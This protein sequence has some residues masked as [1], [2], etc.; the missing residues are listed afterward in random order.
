MI[1]LLVAVS[2]MVHP[3]LDKTQFSNI[4]FELGEFWVIAQQAPNMVLRPN[5][6]IIRAQARITI[7]PAATFS[8]TIEQGM[9][10]AWRAAL[11]GKRVAGEID[12]QE[13]REIQVGGKVLVQ[14]AQFSPQ[15]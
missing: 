14:G 2:A 15:G 4:R 11:G 5:N 7:E 8:G 10:G 13:E 9:E 1:A 3:G 6:E 12:R